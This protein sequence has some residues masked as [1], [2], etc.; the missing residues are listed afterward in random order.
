MSIR[1]S[2]LPVQIAAVAWLRQREWGANND[3]D[4]ELSHAFRWRA[5]PEGED[6]W[7]GIDLQYSN[8]Q[9]YTDDAEDQLIH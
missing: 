5:T 7:V 8:Y 4:P 9:Q 1:L 3:E 6:Y 2:E